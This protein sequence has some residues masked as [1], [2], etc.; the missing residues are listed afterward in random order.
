[1]CFVKPLNYELIKETI[2]IKVRK[3]RPVEQSLSNNNLDIPIES[4]YKDLTQ[5]YLLDVSNFPL[6]TPEEEISYGQLS[7]KNDKAALDKLICSN[8][9]LVINIARR[10]ANRGI[11]LLDLIEEGNLGLIHAAKKFNPALG[12]RFSTYAVWWI[13]SS[14]EKAVINQART[15]KLPIRLAHSVNKYLYVSKLLQ[16]KH[17]NKVDIKDI[18]TELNESIERTRELESLVEKVNSLDE[19]M[20]DDDYPLHEKIADESLSTPEAD[21]VIEDRNRVLLYYIESLN[22]NQKE[23]ILRRFGLLMYSPTTLEEIGEELGLSRER[24][25]QIQVEALK[26]LRGVI[27]QNRLSFDTLVS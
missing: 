22:S 3:M 7:L 6:L 5:L 25:R 2:N 9:R 10:Y 15:I 17:G 21:M 16:Q 26:T 8:V 19:P 20:S 12:F 24:V 11:P 13:K 14:I 27:T 4:N 23:V 1:M 18:A